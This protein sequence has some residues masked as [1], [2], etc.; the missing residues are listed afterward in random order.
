MNNRPKRRAA[1]AE[2]INEGDFLRRCG[3]LLLGFP[4]DKAITRILA[5]LGKA[6]GADRA[7]LIRYNNDFT[8]FWNTHEW[9]RAEV[10]KHVLDLQGVPVEMGAWLHE[11][12]LKDKPVYIEDSKRMPR[13]AKALQ[14]EFLRQRIRSL[15]SVPVFYKGRLML[16]IGYDAAVSKAPW[17]EQE[18]R[19]LRGVGRLIALR[20]LANPA[21]PAF[22]PDDEAQEAATIHLQ[23]S[24]VHRKGF[25]DQITHI[26]ADGDYSWIHL[27]S[28][29]KISDS[30]SLRY[31]ESAL[32]PRR[33]IRISRSAIV[34]LNSVESLDRRGG[35]WKLQLSEVAKPLSV[36]RNYRIDLRHRLD[37]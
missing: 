34:N 31:W 23:E 30:R 8:H 12:L 35:N 10:S 14:A 28:A 21:P 17:S 37:S 4:A 29:R 13:R 22:H 9:T 19:L 5:S 24:S 1:V 7:W 18:V 3:S 32:S 15:L 36:G 16:Q 2:T 26:T 6:H 25:L 11:T 27:L 33:F 20:L